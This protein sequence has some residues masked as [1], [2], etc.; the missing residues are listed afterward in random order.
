MTELFP[1]L[2]EL[3]R[4][5]SSLFLQQDDMTLSSDAVVAKEKD[6]AKLVQKGA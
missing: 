2:Q 6:D 1:S 3:D 5:L 4:A